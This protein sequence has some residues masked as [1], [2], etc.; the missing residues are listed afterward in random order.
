MPSTIF[1]SIQEPLHSLV[2]ELIRSEEV[3][4]EVVYRRYNG[5]AFDPVVKYTKN[6]YKD[7]P[8]SAV[9]MRHSKESVKVSTSDVQVGD[10]L[11]LFD[12]STFPAEHS[13]KDIVVD[14]AGN[15]LGVKGIDRIFD[16]AV[17]VTIVGA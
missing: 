14:E 2:A 13:L 16:F 9:R 12:G 1:S 10:L 5:Q 8:L 3:N 17:S 15:E 4:E 11:F 7:T 6:K